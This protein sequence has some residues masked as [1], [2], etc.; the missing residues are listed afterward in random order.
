MLNR[1]KLLQLSL[2]EIPSETEYLDY[3]QQIDITSE[4]GRAKLIRL[5]CAM[6]NSNPN[7]HSFIFV[8]I[9]DDKTIIGV[10]FL[11]DAK[12]QNAVKG[13]I[14][15]CPKLSYENIN[16]NDTAPEKFIGIITI[17]PSENI[18]Y[19]AKNIWK[20]KEGDKFIR[21]GSTTEK[22][23]GDNE[24]LHKNIRVKQN[25]FES[26]QLTQKATVSLG[27]TLDAVISFYNDT[28]K[29][30]NPRHYVFNDQCVVGISTWYEENS[31]Y[32]SEVTVSI[33]NDQVTYFWSALD[34]V[35]IECLEQHILIE[36]QAL[37]FWQGE[38]IYFP[39]KLTKLDFSKLGSY[40][41]QKKLLLSMPH[42]TTEEIA[43]FINSI[44][45]KLKR[46][47][48]YIEILPY[49]LLLAALNGSQKAVSLLLNKN[50]G[51]IDGALA[52]SYSEAILIYNELKDSVLF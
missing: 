11:D 51:N 4:S 34:T 49:E 38:R 10:P 23:D 21:R 33:L 6:N 9:G 29:E 3:K 13:F 16:F 27:S 43:D 39:F 18:S 12:F 35:K 41:V 44:P 25:Q 2:S 19:V 52:E 26:N 8:G 48:E 28:D 17:Y 22:Y 31:D 37:V 46:E 14:S 45:G 50:N 5:I 32:H 15:N 40:S 1:N 30:Y 47:K 7:A 24:H 20:L 42:L 36:E